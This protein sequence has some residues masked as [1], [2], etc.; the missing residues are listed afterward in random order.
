[1][2]L[3]AKP[4]CVIFYSWQ[5]D[6]KAVKNF[7]QRS[8]KTV[9]GDKYGLV[10]KIDHDTSGLPGSPKIEDAIIEK[11]K[12]SDI[13]VADVTI[14]NQD[15]NGRKVCNPNVLLELGVAISSLGWDRIV[16]LNCMD[17]GKVDELPFDFNHHRTL[18][19]SL[20]NDNKASS[21]LIKSRVE[22]CIEH[23][24]KNGLIYGGNPAVADA[25]RHLYAVITKAI[26]NMLNDGPIVVLKHA[27]EKLHSLEPVIT[28]DSY[29]YLHGIISIL[30]TISESP[31]EKGFYS[32]KF[33]EEY[34]EPVYIEYRDIFPA[35]PTIEVIVEPFYNALNELLP[36]NQQKPFSLTRYIDGKV[37]FSSDP[38][39]LLAYTA[40]GE[41]LLQGYL[42]DNGYFCGF[43]IVN[44]G[45]GLYMG[46]FEDGLRSGEGIVYID[47]D[48]VEPI[49][50]LC[51][52]SWKKDELEN[53]V[54][55]SIATYLYWKN[56]IPKEGLPSSEFLIGHGSFLHGCP[57]DV[58]DGL[59]PVYDV[60]VEAGIGKVAE[61]TLQRYPQEIFTDNRLL[62]EIYTNRMRQYNIPLNR[63]FTKASGIGLNYEHRL[64]GLNRII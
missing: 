50:P 9:K 56:E 4:E 8:L 20:V 51:S 62:L 38:N 15:Y 1:M 13:F 19:F 22:S 37:V 11:I 31:N 42:N 53:G 39:K 46:N 34:I 24:Q 55:Y 17:Y 64:E 52:G 60:K 57:P 28:K 36:L 35:L 48:K 32:S 58:E 54:I 29:D 12:R 5:S 43:Q 23:L 14:I 21:S 44:Y 6:I 47:L 40:T 3:S 61:E 25:K 16:L 45:T 33:V 49:Y 27:L 10:I 30:I 18:S 26:D 41:L 59:C 2:E 7:I 63:I